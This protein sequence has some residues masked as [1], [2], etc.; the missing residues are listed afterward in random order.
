MYSPITIYC[1]NEY[2]DV[3][4]FH[5][6]ILFWIK[7]EDSAVELI[8]FN[9]NI[10]DEM[11]D[12]LGRMLNQEYY[13]GRYARLSEDTRNK[14][15]EI[16]CVLPKRT[17]NLLNEI[18]HGLHLFTCKKTV[19]PYTEFSGMKMINAYD[20][21]YNI[22]SNYE[23]F[24]EMTYGINWKIPDKNY[25]TEKWKIN[26]KSV[27]KYHMKDTKVKGLWIKRHNKLK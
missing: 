26:N 5:L 13:K 14:I 24:L 23:Q 15:L 9:R 16:V 12:G 21:N 20:A 27:I 18:I 25:S 3:H 2:A 8:Q 7:D 22:P 10:F 1:S 11:F 4:G 6:D 19:M 17:Y